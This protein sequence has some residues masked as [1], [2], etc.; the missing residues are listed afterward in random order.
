[1]TAGIDSLPRTSRSSGEKR[2][3]T[4]PPRR[5]RFPFRA[6]VRYDGVKH[7]R[8]PTWVAVAV[9][10]A[11]H[12]GIFWGF[13]H[14]KPPPKKAVFDE[15]QAIAIA[16]PDLRDLEEPEDTAREPG[17]Q[18]EEGTLVPSL[19]DLPSHVDIAT[20]FVQQIDYTTLVPH[21]EIKPEKRIVIPTNLRRGGIVGKGMRDLF[22]LAELDRPPMPIV[23]P[24][25]VFPI[26]LKREVDAAQVTV[27]FV[28]TKSGDVVDALAVSSTH[29]GFEDAA[30]MGV[31][32]WKF[33]PGLKLG[34]RVNVRM[35]VVVNFRLTDSD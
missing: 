27:R 21:P 32:K 1:M 13:E 33:R 25:P 19:P 3:P 23:Q 9:A 29:A 20:D 6:P 28:V 4:L 15:V 2:G 24:S 22:N 8:W 5:G 35:E 10:A 17:E 26:M 34:R 31:S 14:P 12:W 7:S 11:F 30:V 16:M 18:V